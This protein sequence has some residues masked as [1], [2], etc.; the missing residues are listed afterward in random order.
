MNRR[1]A[2]C[3][4]LLGASTAPP[5]MG[6]GASAAPQAAPPSSTLVQAAA[7]ATPL[8]TSETYVLTLTGDAL[9]ASPFDL[10]RLGVIP[11]GRWA[12][13]IPTTPVQHG[14]QFS[15]EISSCSSLG[16]LVTC[17]DAGRLVVARREM[18]D[19]IRLGL[20]DTGWQRNGESAI[21]E[22]G[23]SAVPVVSRKGERELWVIRSNGHLHKRVAHGINTPVILKWR[24]DDL[25]MIAR[26]NAAYVAQRVR[27]ETETLVSATLIE[28][29]WFRGDDRSVRNWAV[30]LPGENSEELRGSQT[31]PIWRQGDPLPGVLELTAAARPM[32]PGG[33]S[34]PVQ[35][36]IDA[37]GR[38]NIVSTMGDDIWCLRFGADGRLQKASKLAL[39]LA[40]NY[41]AIQIDSGGRFYFLEV[42]MDE[43]GMT[44][45]L[46]HLVRLK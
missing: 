2:V 7:T 29:W 38:V 18:A 32:T 9:T 45:K 28:P 31:V 33:F 36:K 35:I 8:A 14:V 1:I 26:V 20:Y 30:G 42:E 3:L 34:S 15:A 13:A 24:D 12:N 27:L 40:G 39:N 19:A 21:S 44:P 4:A 11:F 23:M 41:K 17:E 5:Q 6:L 22:S 25:Y 16:C 46:M 10:D 37:R 43:D